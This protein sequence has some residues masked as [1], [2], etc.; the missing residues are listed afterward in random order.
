MQTIDA[1]K[2]V[3]PLLQVFQGHPVE[4]GYFRRSRAEESV[5]LET[6]S[7]IELF[8]LEKAFLD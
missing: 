5:T 6:Q 1:I 8:A 2:R 3:S 7:S 4:G